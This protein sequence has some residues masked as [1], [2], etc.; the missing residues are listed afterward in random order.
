MGMRSLLILM[1]ALVG[2]PLLADEFSVNPQACATTK[3]NLPC[4]IQIDI[5]FQGEQQQDL[6]LWL[7][8]ASQPLRCYQSLSELNDQLTLALEEDTALELRDA[9]AKLL[10]SMPLSVALY[11]PAPKRKRRGL[12]WDLL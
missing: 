12:N 5:H 3:E 1:F 11:H 7:K 9:N 2:Q 8:H 4:K 10:A 6:C